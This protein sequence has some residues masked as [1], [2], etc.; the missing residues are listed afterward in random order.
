[1]IGWWVARPHQLSRFALGTPDRF[2]ALVGGLAWLTFDLAWKLQQWPTTHDTIGVVVAHLLA[3]A[4][5]LM[6]FSA[7]VAAAVRR[8]VWLR[9]TQTGAR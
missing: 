8:W 9:P 3:S 2:I 7:A 5:T 6:A 1:M 4:G